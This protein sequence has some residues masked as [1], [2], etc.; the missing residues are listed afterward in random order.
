MGKALDIA[1]QIKDKQTRQRFAREKPSLGSYY[2]QAGDSPSMAKYPGMMP[3]THPATSPATAA[4]AKSVSL[5]YGINIDPTGATGGKGPPANSKAVSAPPGYATKPVVNLLSSLPA[6]VGSGRRWR[7]GP[8]AESIGSE[9]V[10]P[11]GP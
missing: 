8:P 9:Q 1:E 6:P 3:M 4:S 11:P 7:Q 5:A 10:T 2:P